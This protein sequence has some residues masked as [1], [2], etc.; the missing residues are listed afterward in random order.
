MFSR[1]MNLFSF[2]FIFCLLFSV[3]QPCQTLTAEDNSCAIAAEKNSLH[4]DSESNESEDCSEFCVCSGCESAEAD[5][6][7]ILSGDNKFVVLIEKRIENSYQNH[8][9]P[10]YLESIWQPPKINLK[11]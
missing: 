2:I 1:T 3:W 8:Y 10:K 4:N 11:A 7:S 6:N 9:S 5:V